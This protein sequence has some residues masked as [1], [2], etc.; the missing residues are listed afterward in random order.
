M[1]VCTE[2][3]IQQNVLSSGNYQT[4]SYTGIFTCHVT[5]LRSQLKKGRSVVLPPPNPVHVSL[6]SSWQKEYRNKCEFLIS[7]G[8]DGE[9]KTIGFRLGKYKGGSCAVVG[10]AETCHVSAEAKRVVSEFQKFIRYYYTILIVHRTTVTYSI[11]F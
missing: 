4:I 6:P 8:A 7:V 11:F 9:D 10:P 1:A 3:E 2:R 5:H